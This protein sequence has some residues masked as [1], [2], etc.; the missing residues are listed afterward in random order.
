MPLTLSNLGELSF[1]STYVS[2]TSSVF[3]LCIDVSV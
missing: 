3:K 1:E 2:S